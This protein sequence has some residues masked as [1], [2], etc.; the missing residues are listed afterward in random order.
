MAFLVCDWR[1]MPA[2]PPVTRAVKYSQ[3]TALIAGIYPILFHLPPGNLFVC[4]FPLFSF[5]IGIVLFCICVCLLCLLGLFRSFVCFVL[6]VCLFVCLFACLACFCSFCICV[7]L[8]VCLFVRSFVRLLVCFVSS[9]SFVRFVRLCGWFLSSSRLL[10][11]P[12]SCSLPP[13]NDRN[14]DPGTHVISGSPAHFGPCLGRIFLSRE[15]TSA[16]SPLV[17]SRLIVKRIFRSFH[18]HIHRSKGNYNPMN[19]TMEGAIHIA[20]D[21]PK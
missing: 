2:P 7:C 16:M 1:T 17:D 11:W 15:K 3:L 4:L 5:L 12:I 8:F 14:S 10:S 21:N 9:V 19:Y 20:G 18:P 6:F 13:I